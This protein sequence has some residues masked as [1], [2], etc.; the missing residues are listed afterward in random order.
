M[1]DCP[2]DATGDV[3]VQMEVER[4]HLRTVADETLV[5]ARKLRIRIAPRPKLPV[6]EAACLEMLLR[7]LLP[8]TRGSI[9]GRKRTQILMRSPSRD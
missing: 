2:L 1:D 4:H 6:A 3:K 9:L 7:L 5:V 8:S